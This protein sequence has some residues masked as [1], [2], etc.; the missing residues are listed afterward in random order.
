MKRAEIARIASE[1]ALAVRKAAS[2]ELERANEQAA[3]LALETELAQKKAKAE[4][5]RL[6]SEAG[7]VIA[8]AQQEPD[9]TQRELTSARRIRTA[10]EALNGDPDEELAPK[11][12]KP[13]AKRAAKKRSS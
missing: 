2:V 3:K 13:K 7:A 8:S 1:V 9:M 10:A 12:A 4:A 5:Q 6:L 11:A